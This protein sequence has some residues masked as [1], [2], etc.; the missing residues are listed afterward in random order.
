L[1]ATPSV[2]DFGQ[3]PQGADSATLTL[4]V[5][6]DGQTDTAANLQAIRTGHASEVIVAAG[7]CQGAPLAAGQSCTLSIKVHPAA[8]GAVT[9]GA[10]VTVQQVGGATQTAATNNIHWTGM[11]VAQIT[12]SDSAHDFST[13]AVGVVSAPFTLALT[14]QAFG[15]LT[16]PL[17]ISVD[18]TD[19]VVSAGGAGVADCGNP[20]FA[21][22]LV[23]S[24][25]CNVFVSFSPKALTPAAKTATLT[26]AST[27]TAGATVALTG[28]AKSALTA[29][30]STAYAFPSTSISGTPPTVDLV[31]TNAPGAPTT[32]QLV[33]TLTGADFRIIAD[34]CTGTTLASNVA[35]TIT[36]RFNPTTAGPKTG[37][38]VVSGTPG[39]SA[40][41]ALTGTAVSP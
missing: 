9:T 13:V 27:S 36:V 4:T 11:A 10:T 8:T 15:Q 21:N 2:L 14:N 32:G 26:I 25:T 3:V 20:T 31:F 24:G 1:T 40:T 22:G 5:T 41:T 19:F 39:N 18:N 28:T 7:G 38:L 30:T 16:G 37:S 35:C 6:N 12:P 23:A 33:A 29:T 17:S 34:G